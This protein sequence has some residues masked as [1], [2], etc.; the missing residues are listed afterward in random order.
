MLTA[1]RRLELRLLGPLEVASDGE[2]LPLGGPRQRALLAFLALHANELVGRDLPRHCAQRD[3]GRR[4]RRCGAD[5]NL[6]GL[7]TSGVDAQIDWNIPAGPGTIALNLLANF[8]N[9]YEVQLLQGSAWQEFAGTIDG[10]QN[11]GIP[12]P[13]WKTL[14]T[15]SYRL[16]SFEASL[17]WRHL[18]EM[19]DITAVTR[20]ASPAPGV[21][22]YD[23]FDLTAAYRF[24][25]KTSIARAGRTTCP[26]RNRRLWGA[27]SARR[28]R[29]RTTS[30]VV[31]TSSVC[32]WGSEERRHAARGVRPSSRQ[33][34]AALEDGFDRRT[35]GCRP[36]MNARAVDSA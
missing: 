28:S 15:L 17:R 10:T 1:A 24:N 34:L 29:V 14:T 33:R 9:S 4:G 12:V 30:L 25:D 31:T 26:T 27:P 7:R 16:P 22:T 13:D 2:P 6:G 20:P 21:P 35:G 8:T 3:D 36:S 5:L 18:P 19:D 11:G 23:L 32:S